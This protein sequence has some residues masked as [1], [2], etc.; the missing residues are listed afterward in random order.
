MAAK[1]SYLNV[2]KL[3]NLNVN[4]FSDRLEELFE[5][6]HLYRTMDGR[7]L[8]FEQGTEYTPPQRFQIKQDHQQHQVRH[9]NRNEK[10]K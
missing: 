5:G 2:H 10:K 7:I 1:R 3:S 4:Q 8:D 9:V 6:A